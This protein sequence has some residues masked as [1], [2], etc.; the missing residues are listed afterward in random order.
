MLKSEL[1]N[2][3]RVVGFI[4]TRYHIFSYPPDQL[5]AKSGERALSW[6]SLILG[7]GFYEGK[8]AISGPVG[9][10]SGRNA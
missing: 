7:I 4:F 5:L 9:I 1:A 3:G 2:D 10:T 8:G 6:I